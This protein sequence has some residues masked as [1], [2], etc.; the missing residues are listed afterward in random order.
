[1]I[2]GDETWVYG[3]DP[4]TKVQLSQ[5]KHS[6]STRPKKAQ[7]VRSKVKVLLTVFFDYRGIVH[8]SYAPNTTWKSSI[9][10]VMHFGARNQTVGPHAIGN[11]IMTM[12][13]LIHHTWFRVSWPNMAFQLFA[14]LPTLQTGSLWFLVV[15]QIEEATEGFL[16][17]QPR[18][19]HAEHDGAEKPSR[20]S[21]PEM[22]PAVDGKLG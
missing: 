9:I 14:R 5:W 2:I 1:V 13:Q 6:S 22:L 12:P 20:R 11:C 21:F 4:E 8:H 16:F 18:G 10:F 15:S 3:Y 17:W 19:H 7:W